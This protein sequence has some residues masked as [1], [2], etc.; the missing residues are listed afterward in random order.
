MHETMPT[1]QLP[2]I[3]ARIGLPTYR[4]SKYITSLISPKQDFFLQPQE[5]LN[6]RTPPPV[7]SGQPSNS[8]WSR[9]LPF[10][11]TLLRRREDGSLGVSVYRK[12]IHTCRPLSPLRL[13]FDPC[14]ER[15][16]EMSTHRTT[17]RKK[18]T[19]LLKFSSRTVTL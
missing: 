13:S 3:H 1:I 5:G 2:N 4:A 15:C 17:F 10:F 19:T 7:G 14:E 12:P 11:D 18:F 9:T 6:Q 16:G 8:L